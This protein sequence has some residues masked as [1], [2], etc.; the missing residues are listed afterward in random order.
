MNVML[1][2]QN[3]MDMAIRDIKRLAANTARQRNVE[4]AAPFAQNDHDALHDVLDAV[5]S[6]WVGQLQE[7]RRNAERIEHLVIERVG[8]IKADVTQLFV[9]GAAV[10]SEA[11]RGEDVN[12]KLL[13][14]LAKLESRN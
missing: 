6:D 13:A 1:E 4:R 11:Q 8:K 7:V 3:E 9:L 2:M 12:A 14:E 5:A 10:R